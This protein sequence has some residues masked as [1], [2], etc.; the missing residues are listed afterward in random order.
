MK[1]IL[2]FLSVIGLLITSCGSDFKI[3]LHDSTNFKNDKKEILL[4]NEKFYSTLVN[5]PGTGKIKIEKAFNSLGIFEPIIFSVFRG[6]VRRKKVE[7]HGNRRSSIRGPDINHEFDYDYYFFYLQYHIEMFIAKLPSIPYHVSAKWHSSDTTFFQTRDNVSNKTAYIV[8]DKTDS[9][10]FILNGK[11]KMINIS[12]LLANSELPLENRNVDFFRELLNTIVLD[13]CS[14]NLYA[15]FNFW[16]AIHNNKNIFYDS[17]IDTIN[18]KP[19]YYFPNKERNIG[20][21]VKFQTKEI[22]Y[23]PVKFFPKRIDRDVLNIKYVNNVYGVNQFFMDH[24]LTSGYV[25]PY[26]QKF[27]NQLSE[28]GFVLCFKRSKNRINEAIAFYK[29]KKDLSIDDVLGE[30]IAF[31]RQWKLSEIDLNI[32]SVLMKKCAFR[33]N[34]NCLQIKSSSDTPYSQEIPLWSKNIKE[35]YIPINELDGFGNFDGGTVT[36][37]WENNNEI[38]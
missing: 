14:E 6:G 3:N 11:F 25:H 31:C 2:L 17:I 26:T 38:L 23:I 29:R 12:D 19:I 9:S 37:I 22:S 13:K 36:I 28:D 27:F 24:D 20:S 33:S 10:L 34:C 30:N 16:E 7:S 4:I 21:Q 5:T 1:K 18:T 8:Q 32:N 35:G 15:L